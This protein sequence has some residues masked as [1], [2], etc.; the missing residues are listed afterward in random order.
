MVRRAA[1]A[2]P[3]VAGCNGCVEAD[4]LPPAAIVLVLDGVRTDEFSSRF[5]SDLTGVPGDEY[6]AETWRAVAPDATVV[7]AALN[8]GITITA[9]AHASMVVGRDEALANFPV[10]TARGPGRY[11]PEL[12]T[13]FEEARAQ[14]G[15]GE[16]EVF[17][18]ANTEL[19]S[20]VAESLYPGFD[21]GARYDLV[22]DNGKPVNDDTPVMEELLARIEA[23]GPRLVFVN[24]HDV[25]RAGHYGEG[26]A[27]IDDVAKIDGL[28]ADFWKALE[29][30]HPDL[31]PSLLLVVTADHG[32][33]R[34]DDH[35]GF[36]NHGDA[37]T[38]CREV[39]LMLLGAA[40]AGQD[41]DATVT[42]V[43]LAPTLAAHL[44]I[45]LPWA[46]GLPFAEALGALDTPRR[47]GDVDVSAS[48][49]RIAL[50]SWRDDRE[51]RSEVVVDGEVVS[52]PGIHAAEAPTLLYTA[53]GA[54]VCFR[55]IDLAT[56]EDT[57]PW[58][59]RCLAESDGAW[60]EMGFPDDEVG[61]FFRASLTERDGRLWAAWPNNP[62]GM[63]DLGEEGGVGLAVAAWDPATGWTDRLWAR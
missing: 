13:I 33:H 46:E 48:G 30:D 14:L 38:G 59:A 49:E 10:D 22:L 42:S 27:Y 60:V 63:T 3:L 23:G 54:R 26:D 53:G 6:A 57:L 11:L 20:P 61:P 62:H 24:L 47:S 17:F 32:R 41:L 12:P 7:R 35:D 43:D 2:L 44:G 1:L 40:K 9:P 37:C 19:L 8:P 21:G 25:D 51:A 18:L 34:H 31:V 15:L 29:R 58:R 56:G 5:A 4:P 28:L 55:E 52:T 16:D 50:R 39:P 45:D 36:H